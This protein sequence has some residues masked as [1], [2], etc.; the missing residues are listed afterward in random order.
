MPSL[1]S[2]PLVKSQFIVTSSIFPGLTFT[3]FNG[4]SDTSTVTDYADGLEFRRFNLVGPPKLDPMTITIPF[5]PEDNKD[6]IEYQRNNPCQRFVL[7]VTPVI[8]NPNS[9]TQFVEVAGNTLY[10][11]GCQLTSVKAY[12]VDRSSTDVSVIE[13]GFVGDDYYLG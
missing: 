9:S 2:P 6:L 12:S 13:L 1:T 3:V 11:T 7:S 5:S 10:I 4:L 8:C